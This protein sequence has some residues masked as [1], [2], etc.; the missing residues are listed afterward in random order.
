M[1]M[2]IPTSPIGNGCYNQADAYDFDAD[3]FD[4]P[5]D[6]ENEN[7][8]SE[9]LWM[10]NEEEFDKMEM[11]RLEE[12]EIMQQCFEAMLEDELE[13][14]LARIDTSGAEELSDVLSSLSVTTEDV[15]K[16]T[17]NPLAAEFVPAVSLV[18]A[19]T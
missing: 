14:E 11:Q 7:D 6:L 17:L 19:S 10:E 18:P 1:I 3:E 15:E 4:I 12:Q 13:A 9:Y 16:S 5:S 2:K 8:F